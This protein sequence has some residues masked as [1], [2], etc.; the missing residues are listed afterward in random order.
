MAEFLKGRRKLS[1]ISAIRP[2]N[3]GSKKAIIFLYYSWE[4]EQKGY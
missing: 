4:K 3:I 1:P 2:K